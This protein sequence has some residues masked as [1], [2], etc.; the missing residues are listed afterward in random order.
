MDYSI[1]D[2]EVFNDCLKAL[3]SGMTVYLRDGVYYDRVV[4]FSI[5][6]NNYLNTIVLLL[7][8]NGSDNDDYLIC[9]SR[10]YSDSDLYTPTNIR[11][12]ESSP[13]EILVE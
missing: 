9:P 10:G 8:S 5:N 2:T 4:A 1:Y 11:I 13:P 3:D 12:E 7:F 6:Y